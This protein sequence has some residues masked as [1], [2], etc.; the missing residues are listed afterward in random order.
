MAF[1]SHTD[2]SFF[3]ILYQNHVSGLEIKAR[4]GEWL[5][6]EFPPKSFIVMAGDACQVYPQT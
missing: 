3:T 1:P 5:S 6:I 2:K 4:N